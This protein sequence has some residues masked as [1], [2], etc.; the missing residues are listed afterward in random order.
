MV[1]GAAA[2]GVKRRFFLLGKLFPYAE[3][4]CLAMDVVI[5][6]G[7]YVPSGEEEDV[8]EGCGYVAGGAHFVWMCLCFVMGFEFCG[9]RI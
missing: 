8:E 2:D 9:A 7:Y 6:G 4:W 5:G 1:G 3:D